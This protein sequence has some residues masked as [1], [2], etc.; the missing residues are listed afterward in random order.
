MIHIHNKMENDNSNVVTPDR[1]L[2]RVVK[3]LSIT[4]IVGADQIESA[5]VLGWNVVTKKGEFKVGDLAIYYSIGSVLPKD[6]PDTAFLEGKVLKTRKI[7]GTIS[8]GLLGPLKWVIPYGL[9]P[10][11]LKED[12]DLT[13]QLNVKKWVPKEEMSLYENEGKTKSIFPSIIRKTD[14]DRVQDRVK[15]L[16]ELQGKNIVIT[17]KYD[18]TSTTFM[19]LNNIF[20]ICGRNNAL[21]QDSAESFHY[22]EIAKRYSIEENMLKLGKNIAIQG[23][24]IGQRKDGK[25]KI[26]GNRHKVKDFEFYVFNIF[27]IDKQYY[28]NW[29]EIIEITSALGLKTVPVIYKGIMK[30]EWLNVKALIDM[31]TEQKYDTGEICEG[32][33]IKSDLGYGFPR[34]S[35]KA[36]SNEYL[37]KYRL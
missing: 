15:K 11:D 6:N 29:T 25:F 24:L 4:P 37:L 21:L 20:T 2:A 22:F 13:E 18:G 3:V 33:V 31:A 27:D 8:Q 36:I 1:T 28:M 17:Q 23:E 5:E 19:V 9:N 26:N 16:I 34:T 32:I 10:E 12:T 7:L 30:D 14:E 35:F